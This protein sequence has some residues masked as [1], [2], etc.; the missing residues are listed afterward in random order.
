MGEAPRSFDDIAG[1]I[2]DG[3]VDSDDSATVFSRKEVILTLKEKFRSAGEERQKELLSRYGAELDRREFLKLL[4]AAGAA[5]AVTAGGA[6]FLLGKKVFSD[7]TDNTITGMATSGV[8]TIAASG[9]TV[10][11]GAG[12][13]WQNKIVDLT[14]GEDISLVAKTANWTVRNVGITGEDMSGTALWG[15][16]DSGGG[17][18]LFENVYMGDGAASGNPSSHGYGANG[19]WID[20][21]HS[22]H[23]TIRCLNVAGWADNGVYG[24]EDYPGSLLIENCYGHD[25]Y[26]STFR[27]GDD[28]VIRNSVAYNTNEGYNGRPIWVWPGGE[29]QTEIVGC[30]ADAGSYANGDAIWIGRDFGH[31]VVRITDTRHTGINER[32]S[33]EVIDGGGNGNNPSRTPPSCVPMSAEAAA[34]GEASTNGDTAGADAGGSFKLC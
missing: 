3:L 18:S 34:T 26:V 24:S 31:T 7:H 30:H 2:R 33:V 13:T 12:E 15:V 19:I 14:T 9:Q 25:N 32:G 5:G 28:A 10:R 4:G 6:G 27:T 1:A 17:T 8:E 29:G 16:A 23:L 21:E 11:I 20:P 22:G